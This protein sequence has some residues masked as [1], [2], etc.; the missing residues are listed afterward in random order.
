MEGR[1]EGR[2]EIRG[3]GVEGRVE[4]GERGRKSVA[5]MDAAGGAGERP[6]TRWMRGS[7]EVVGG[8]AVVVVSDQHV[9]L[10]MDSFT[11]RHTH[12]RTHTCTHTR[13]PH[14]RAHTRTHTHTRAH[15]HTHTHMD[16]EG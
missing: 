16:R 9:G 11:G 1:R 7:E 4:G 14:T 2:E 5:S 13:T 6:E 3:E 12:A 8:G 15:T 10:L